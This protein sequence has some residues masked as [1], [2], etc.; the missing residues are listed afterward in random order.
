MKLLAIDTALNAVAVCVSRQGEPAPLFSQRSVMERGHAEALIPLVQDLIARSGHSF[1]E[2]QKIAVSV[3]P[4]SFTGMRV[5][6][7]AA[8]AF[9]VALEVPVVGVSALAALA[10]PLR[11][12]SSETDIVVVIDAR[13]GNVYSQRFSSIQPPAT[14]KVGTREALLQDLGSDAVTFV[15]PGAAAVFELSCLKGRQDIL[16]AGPQECDIGII[17]QLGWRAE[18]ETAPPI[19]L[20]L[21]SPQYR[22]VGDSLPKGTDP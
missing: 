6:I 1:S 7:A 19:P 14:A 10:V 15:G 9:G 4:G 22:R 3:G 12:K 16:A 8:R 5:G 11:L 21:S 2:I 13:N 17:A 18:P 20:Y